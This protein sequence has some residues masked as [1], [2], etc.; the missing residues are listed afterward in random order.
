M[1]ELI[2]IYKSRQDIRLFPTAKEATNYIGLLSNKPRFLLLYDN[3]NQLI[4]EERR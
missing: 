1:F 2:L 4:H 3:N